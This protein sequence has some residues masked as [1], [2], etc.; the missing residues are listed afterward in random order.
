MSRQRRG[1]TGFQ[2]QG[3]FAT[4]GGGGDNYFKRAEVFAQL[5]Y[6]TALLKDSDITTPAHRQQ[7][8]HCRASGVTIFEWGNGFSTEAALLAWCPTETIRD[9]V[10][11]AAGLN[12]QQQVDQ[13]IHNCSQGAYNFDTCTGEPTEEMRTPVAHAAGKY[14]WFKTIGKA[15]DLAENIVGPVINQF[16]RPFKAI[17]RDL[18]AWAAENGDPR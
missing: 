16:S 9:I 7:T 17:I 10:L 5:G 18:L 12:S 6:R 8:E 2:D 1:R 15:E 3:A 13:H 11:L 4:D 14:G